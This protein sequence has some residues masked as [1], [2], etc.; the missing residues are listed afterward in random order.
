MEKVEAVMMVTGTNEQERGQFAPVPSCCS[1]TYGERQFN[2]L[3]AATR[4]SD[5]TLP[6]LIEIATHVSACFQIAMFF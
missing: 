4:S 1:H 3:N 2:R 5:T 6:D